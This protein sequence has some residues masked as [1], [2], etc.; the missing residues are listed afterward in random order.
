ML[1]VCDRDPQMVL[2]TE[3]SVSALCEAVPE[4][5]HYE[6]AS[7]LPFRSSTFPSL[8]MCLHTGLEHDPA[9]ENF[10]S[11]LLYSPPVTP[12]QGVEEQVGRR[13]SPITT[14]GLAK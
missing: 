14:G 4:L 1:G 3:A 10:R 2:I 6:T 12:L 8:R 11:V 5:R 13:T 9:V 7:G